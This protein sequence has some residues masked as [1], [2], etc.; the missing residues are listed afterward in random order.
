ME[1]PPAV[2]KQWRYV[3]LWDKEVRL[4]FRNHRLRI[5]FCMSMTK[6]TIAPEKTQPAAAWYGACM[7]HLM[8]IDTTSYAIYPLITLSEAQEDLGKDVVVGILWE[9]IIYLHHRLKRKIPMLTALWSGKKQQVSGS[10]TQDFILDEIRD[11]E[12]SGWKGLEQAIDY[13]K[14]H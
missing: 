5:N 13:V 4:H 6:N 1:A 12:I 3:Y 9:S 11:C 14:R 2:M 8:L 10:A 7:H